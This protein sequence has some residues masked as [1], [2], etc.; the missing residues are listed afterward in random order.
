MKPKLILRILSVFLSVLYNS[1]FCQD[2][3]LSQF[4]E[5]PLVRNPALAGLFTGDIRLQAVHRNQ[6]ESVGYPYQTTALS[7]EYKFAVGGGN[8]FMTAG[9]NAFYDMAGIARLKTLQVMPALNFHKSL[10][11]ERNSYL[12]AGFMAGFVQRQ[13]D[14]QKLTFDNQY[15]NGSFNPT[16]GSGENFVG[17]SRTVADFALGLVY[18]S[19]LGENG[20]W[21]AGGSLWHFNKPKVNF[22]QENIQLSPK[23]QANAGIK[24]PISNLV[25][26]QAELNYTRQGQ[27]SETIGGIL[28]SYSL[29]D[30]LEQPDSRIKNLRIGG[31]L[32]MRLNDALVPVIRIGYNHLDVGLSYDVNTSQ[33]KTASQNRG[34]FELSFSFRA[35]TTNGNTSLNSVRC[36]RF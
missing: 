1:A 17:L 23:W 36:P 2:I 13:F 24:M 29:T 10:S 25:D 32:M 34:G 27:Y 20:N 9:I 8:D 26:L 18:S 19:Q 16:A 7:G 6:W 15:N 22:L 28:L 12:S 14:G 35:F 5:T 3:H 30:R 11:A 21:Y 31:G 33:L 4:F